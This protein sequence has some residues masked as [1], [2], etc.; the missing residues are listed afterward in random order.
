M[1]DEL[2]GSLSAHGGQALKSNLTFSYGYWEQPLPG[3]LASVMKKSAPTPDNQELI[4]SNVSP[5]PAQRRL[6]LGVVL[7]LLVCSVGLAGPLSTQPLGRIDAFMPAY[8]TAIFVSDS[9][10][11]VLL[12]AQFSVLR[13]PALLALASGY[14]WSGFI[15]IPWVL[16]FPGVLPQAVHWAPAFKVRRGSIFSGMKASFFP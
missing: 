14:L 16:T 10:T 11:A 15:A 6:A 12:F 1:S 2:N 7:V 5:S 9:I 4:L 3:R 13:S 8:G